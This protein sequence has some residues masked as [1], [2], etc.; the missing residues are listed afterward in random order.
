MQTRDLHQVSESCFEIPAAAGMNVPARV[1]AD[2]P[3]LEEMDEKVREQITNVA[4]LP[5]IVKAAFAMPDAHWGYGFP[6]GGVAAFDP[7]RG[8]VI[9][10][11][12]IGYDI[13]CG[14]RALRTGLPE[15]EVAPH[16]EEVATALFERVPAG[17]GSEGKIRL[18][19]KGLD[20]VL[21]GGAR[22]AVEQGYG[23]AGD[24]EFVEERGCME[25]ADP[26]AVS[27]TA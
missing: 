20:E 10:M 7:G 1:F 23:E 24:L 12:G 5:G 25:G 8:G 9:S 26:G 13:S 22:W 16:L 15:E 18:D 2:R 21:L 19:R 3:L 6:I 4:R 11:G 27:D 14:V 17:V